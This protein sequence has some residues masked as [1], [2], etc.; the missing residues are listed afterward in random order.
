MRDWNDRRKRIFMRASH[1]GMK[2][3]DILLGRYA[4]DAL[5]D[6]DE[7]QL[8]AL[9]TLM[10]ESDQ[11]LFLWVTGQRAAPPVHMGALEHIRN[12]H[13]IKSESS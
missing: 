9:E 4:Q 2:E 5:S 6:L 12:H 8:D 1:R 3:M 10:D 7:S 11:D 13:G